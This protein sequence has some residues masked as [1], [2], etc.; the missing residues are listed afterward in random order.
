MSTMRVDTDRLMFQTL[1]T[2][3]FQNIWNMPLTECRRNITLR[4]ESKGRSCVNTVNLGCMYTDLPYASMTQKKSYYVYSAAKCCMGGIVVD[5]TLPEIEAGLPARY[6]DTNAQSGTPSSKYCDGW[7][8]LKDYLNLRPFDLR[9]H[10][11][12]GEWL[13][14]DEIMIKNHPY[15]DMFLIAI[16]KTMAKQILGDDYK[17]MT[18][19]MSVYY[20]SDNTLTNLQ[21]SS[22]YI[23]CFHPKK[24]NNEQL[25]AAFSSYYHLTDEE[26]GRTM[27]FIDGREAV[28]QALED[29][30]FG[31]YV[32]IVTDPDIIC[33]IVLDMTDPEHN[34]IY[35]SVADNTFKYIIHIPKQANPN[36]YIITHNTCDVF[37]R[38]LNTSVIENARLKGLFVH[39]FNTSDYE[40]TLTTDTTFVAGRNYF[41]LEAG[42]FKQASVVAGDPVP[43]NTYYVP[44]RELYD[45]KITQIT[46]N[47]FG[48]SE[49]LLQPYMEHIGSSEC[50]LRIV[51][52]QHKKRNK[53]NYDCN[54]LR[55]LYS[56]DDAT[57]LKMLLGEG[58][59]TLEFWK[60]SELEQSPY[61]KML[62]EVPADVT[63]ANAEKYISA[64]GYYNSMSIITPKVNRYV[65]GPDN[66]HT[67]NVGIPV[68]MLACGSDIEAIVS[69]NGLKLS[70]GSYTT[71][72]NNQYLDVTVDD[73]IELK[74]NDRIIVE[75]F[76]APKLKASYFTP[77]EDNLI[78]W[79]DLD[80]DYDV[81]KVFDN[82][83]LSSAD[84][85]YLKNYIPSVNTEFQHVDDNELGT[86]IINDEIG[87]FYTNRNGVETFV[88]HK[89][90]SKRR[91]VFSNL[92]IGNKFLIVSKEVYAEFSNPEIELY[93]GNTNL[94]TI[95]YPEGTTSDMLHSGMLMIKGTQW[96]TGEEI[97]IPIINQDWNVVCY[98]NG[99]ELVRDIDY[100]FKDIFGSALINRTVFFNNISYLDND[101]NQF[102]IIVTSDLPFM[103]YN[104]FIHKYTSNRIDPDRVVGKIEEI[105]PYVFWFNNLCTACVD[106]SAISGINTFDGS[107]WVTEGCRQGALYG[108][109]G[110]VPSEAKE[111]LD[112]FLSNE[113]DIRKLT[114]IAEY[115]RSR[116]V[117]GTPS[118]EVIEYS[119]HIASITMNAIVNDVLT[120]K[121][122]LNYEDNVVEMRNQISEYNSL[123]KYDSVMTGV[124]TELTIF[125]AGSS[126]VNN[127]YKMFDTTATGTDRMW[128]NDTVRLA[129]RWS[130]NRERWEIISTV[131][132]K[133]ND[134]Y[135]FSTGPSD[136]F[137]PWDLNWEVGSVGQGAVP[138]FTE[139]ALD[140]RYIDLFPSYS[141]DLH[142]VIDDIV[143]RQAI[144]AIFPVDSIR[145]GDTVR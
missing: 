128:R 144:K 86:I 28:P 77:T 121:K 15:E 25:N 98:L 2:H 114:A 100:M 115:I 37:I 133:P 67:F 13:Y 126:V 1:E 73:S 111:F 116:V 107:L 23:N 42:E 76:D 65:F 124:A 20:D 84:D 137:D 105:N 52:R 145:D 35:R 88:A 140:L 79:I 91:L 120:G 24:G 134:I 62:F 72:R 14:R 78:M 110:Y 131:A 10:G 89:D 27:C 53:L 102:E 125:G 55:N 108:V 60:A 123:K 32:E 138:R 63:L 11:T 12:N 92:K 82:V 87:D 68:S 101:D 69:V 22:P 4:A 81:Y 31:Q 19:Y 5:T 93:G 122:R 139:G 34:N 85:Y 66:T 36:N 47:D 129:V 106:G 8:S 46:H 41:I 3:L 112:R 54:F 16:E 119:H 94:S 56:Y 103:E 95:E 64:L 21:S 58:P 43:A 40:Y 135:Y 127:T 45:K 118:L 30:K 17:F 142:V 18:M 71:I 26:K 104:G 61:I 50:A 39:R 6:R 29:I 109:R 44:G 130:A 143:L 48:I 38:P 57:I 9:I 75:L 7:V 97:S 70:K 49:K 136:R 99:C 96:L 51:V 90:G 74:T 59:A 113:E 141:S 83:E 132:T 80:A 117:D 33:N